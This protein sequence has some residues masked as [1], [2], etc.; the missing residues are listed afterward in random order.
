VTS[1]R[2]AW[3]ERVV[4]AP[5]DDEETRHRKVQF[6]LASV[7]VTPAGAVW[8]AIYFAYGERTVA[9]FPAAYAVL[10]LLDFAVLLRLRRYELFRLVQQA[11]IL[12]LPAALQAGLGGFVGGSMV[13]VWSFLAV[14]MAVL[15]A[16]MREARWWFAAFLVAV[17]A[18]AL[19]EPHLTVDNLLPHS[20]ILGFFVLNVSTVASIAFLVLYAF[21]ADRRRLRE[22]EVAYLKQDLLLRQSER[23]ATLG[24]LAAGVAH[25]LN[26]PAA[27]TRR[28]AD[29]LREAFARLEQAHL[30]LGTAA[31]TPTRRDALRALEEEARARATRPS[32]LDPVARSDREAAVEQWLEQRGVTDP[33]DL[34]PALVAQG[35][36]PARLAQLATAFPGDTLEPAVRWTASV[37]PVYALL[38][39][40][41]QGSS[42]VS[43]IVRALK[44]YSYLGQAPAQ[45]VD[46]HEG[47][48]DTLVILRN[49]LNQGITVHRDYGA[50]VPPVTAYGSELNQVWTNLLDNAADALG[51]KGGGA[52]TIRTSRRDGWAV[53][54]IEDDGPGIPPAIQSKVFDPFF[55]T[56]APGQGTGLGLATCHSIVTE[57]HKGAIT[58]ESRPGFTRFTVRLPLATPSATPPAG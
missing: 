49:K 40:I 51:G 10:T 21:V 19:L 58:V 6:T 2:T 55:T 47:L 35:L 3:L 5:G 27:A 7:L 54:E 32:D 36:D 50:D 46:L 41:G 33:W 42:R 8:A 13:I 43:E 9:L 30:R 4:C 24:T 48:D 26:N 28:A 57:R 23:L 22:L 18:S 34:A 39:E 56:K 25:E 15:F 31:L 44:G 38:H 14:L 53:V 12:V 20:L 17:V 37:F 11:L 1:D 52:I 29:Q 45:A 16:G